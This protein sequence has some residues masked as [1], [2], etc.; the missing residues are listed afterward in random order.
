MGGFEAGVLGE[1]LQRAQPAASDVPLSDEFETRGSPH[2][3]YRVPLYTQDPR[4]ARLA[5]SYD[6]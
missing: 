1:R 4:Y 6:F 2:P 5:V 3:I